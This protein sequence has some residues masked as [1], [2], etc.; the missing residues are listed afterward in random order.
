M[1]DKAATLRAHGSA[2]GK[3]TNWWFDY[4]KTTSYGQ[5]TTHRDGGSGTGQSNVSERVTGL[6]PDTLYHYRACASNADGGGCTPDATFRTGSLGLLPGLPGDRRV[7]RPEPAHVRA[8][9]ARRPGLR[10]REERPDQGLRQPERHRR[11]TVVADL[12]TKVHDYWDRGLL[13][14]AA[15]SRV[16]RPSRSCTCSYTHDAAIGGDGAEVGRH[17][18]PDPP[19]A[20]TDGCVISGRLSRLQVTGNQAGPEQVLIEDWC[21]QFPSHSIGDLAFGADGALYATGGDGASF[22]YA[23]YGQSGNPKNPCDDP[24][25]GSRR[26]HDAADRRGRCAAL[27]GRRDGR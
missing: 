9:L 27:P 8:L 20:N 15:R 3:P 1:T 18:C 19:G 5:S 14:F 16:S 7:R 26:H 6:D 13:G 10:R 22:N 23:D 11:A 21:Q 2:G 12:R 24:P 17:V 25:G 4:G